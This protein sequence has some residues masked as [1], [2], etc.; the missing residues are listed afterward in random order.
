MNNKRQ[1]RSNCR[2][3]YSDLGLNFNNG[4]CNEIQNNGCNDSC[5]NCIDNCNCCSSTT[6]QVGRTITGNPGTNAFVFNSGTDENV[7]LDFVIPQGVQGPAGVQGPQGIAGIQGPTG[8][9]GP[10]GPASVTAYG[11][12][13]NNTPDVITVAAGATETLPLT[14]DMPASQVTSGTDS[15]VITEAGDYEINYYVNGTTAAA[16]TYTVTALDNGT[17]IAGSDRAATGDST[18]DFSGNVIA[19]LS[20]GDVITLGISSAAGGTFT[21][22]DGTNVTLTVTLLA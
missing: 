19:M 22:T 8:P 10:T 9:T 11:G 13:Y 1:D 4:F 14:N 12:A 16:G 2:G 7:I 17:A 3:R 5:N 21:L 6:V 15:L 20:A 18:L